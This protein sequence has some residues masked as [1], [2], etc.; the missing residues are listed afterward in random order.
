ML[1]HESRWW[2]FLYYMLKCKSFNISILTTCLHFK[3]NILHL[4]KL[5]VVKRVWNIK[6]F[7]MNVSLHALF[8]YT[9]KWSFNTFRKSYFLK[10][11]F[12]ISTQNKCFLLYICIQIEN[13]CKIYIY[14]YLHSI[15]NMHE[16]YVCTYL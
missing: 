5:I 3:F 4:Y 16:H 2:F 12:Q 7:W 11:P 13:R 9:K 10:D 1:H 14:I 6:Q 8:Y 15:S